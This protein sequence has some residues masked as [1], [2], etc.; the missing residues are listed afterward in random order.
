MYNQINKHAQEVINTTGCLSTKRVLK[1]NLLA[2][3]IKCFRQ[4]L[5]PQHFTDEKVI[6][7]LIWAYVATLW[8][9]GVTK[10]T[11]LYQ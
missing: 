6:D 5:K 2:L 11:I 4:T 7:S 9:G 1:H 8:D 3:A 10:G